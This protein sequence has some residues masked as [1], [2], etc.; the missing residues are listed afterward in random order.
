V[1]RWGILKK[2]IRLTKSVDLS[3]PDE[4]EE[5][6]LDVISGLIAEVFGNEISVKDLDDGADLSDMIAC[7]QMIVAKAS[8]IIQNPTP[9][10]R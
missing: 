4:L 10:A 8:G 9:P 5:A 6:D 2:V 3:Q 7:L 1:I